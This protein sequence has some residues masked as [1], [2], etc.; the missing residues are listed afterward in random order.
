MRRY[1]IDLRRPRDETAAGGQRLR[2]RAHPQVDA[3]LDAQ[4]LGGAGAARP[5]HAGAVRLVDHQP[6][7]VALAQLADLAQRRDVA[8]HREDAVDDDQ[9]AAAVAARALQGLLQFVQAVVPEGAQLRAR[10]HAAVED[11]GVVAGVGD[12]GVTGCEDRAQ[13]ADVGLVAGREDDRVLGTDP[14]G[15]LALEL[16][17]QRDRAVQQARSRQ[18]CSVAVQRILRA[19]Q[20]AL[21]AGQAEVVVGAQHDPLGSLHLD[22]RHRRR[23][24][25]ME[26][27]EDVRLARGRE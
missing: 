2:E 4:Q 6:R 25:Q 11:R 12:H 10:E 14:L 15:D 20:H 13:R 26:V 24:E 19:A 27:G 9:H 3:I 18:A 1:S 21:V 16:E 8:L 17:V 7:A 5:E 22:D 23:G